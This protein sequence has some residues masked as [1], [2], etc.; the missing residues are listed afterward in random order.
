M[1]RELFYLLLACAVLAIVAVPV[2]SAVF[3]LGFVHGDSPCVLCWAQRTGMLLIALMGLF[4]LRYGP[5]PRYLGLSILLAGWGV[6]MAVRH[7]AAHVVRDVGQGFSAELLGAHTYTWSAAIF[8]SCVMAMGVLLLV[9]RDGDASAE[10]RALRPLDRVAMWAFLVVVAGNIVQSFAST[11]PPPYM[12]QSDPVRFS[13]N[14]RYWVWSLE[15]YEPA[16]VSWRGRWGIERPSTEALD[17]HPARG[18]LGALPVLPARRTLQ[19]SLPLEG[20]VTDLAYDAAGNRFALATARG[21]YLVSD[22]L[23]RVLRHTVV[24]TGFAVDLAEFAGVA[25]VDP[26][27]VIAVSRNKSYVVLKE[28]GAADPVSNYRFFLEAPEAFDQLARSR[29]ATIRA[30]MM[31]V[32]S[33]AF[34]PASDAFYTVTVPNRQVRPLVVSRFDRG[35]RTLSAEFVPGVGPGLS[36]AAGRS[37]DEFHVTG[38]AAVD[39]RLYG[40][41]AAYATL[42]V[43]DPAARALV[44]A[45]ALEGVRA[46]VGLAVKGDEVFVVDAGGRVSV[47]ALPGVETAAW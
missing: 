17:A 47:H 22:G 34:D 4:V 46:P 42:L 25:F 19:A 38:L 41:S 31:Y 7:S 1:R 5:R 13:F 6:F 33:V 39:G 28:N 32:Q 29:F 8:W 37:I 12:G 26:A 9:L 23:D 43:I 14:P 24:D 27:T 45:H 20:P 10:R 36:L 35:D 3:Y 44:G 2:G 40:V 21:V 18:P 16:P 11:G 15:E 30:R